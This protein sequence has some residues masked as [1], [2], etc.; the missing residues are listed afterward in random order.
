MHLENKAQY[1]AVVAD[2]G[3][4]CAVDHQ[5]MSPGR[6]QV[7]AAAGK[8][9]VGQLFGIG[10]LFDGELTRKQLFERGTE[11]AGFTEFEQGLGRGID[12]RQAQIPAEHE[13]GGTEIVDQFTVKLCL[14]HYLHGNP[15]GRLPRRER[16][17]GRPS[18][19]P[20]HQS[21]TCAS[22]KHSPKQNQHTSSAGTLVIVSTNYYGVCTQATG[23]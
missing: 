14:T 12:E 15:D 1:F 22:V 4:D 3:G 9:V 16:V 21:K 23:D 20:V 7:D 8:G 13:H 6:G 10:Q 17:P 5:L 19:L 18:R 11:A 2:Q